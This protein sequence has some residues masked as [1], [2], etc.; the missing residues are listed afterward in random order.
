M[1]IYLGSEIFF[2]KEKAKEIRFNEHMFSLEKITFIHDHLL[3][4]L[5]TIIYF[6]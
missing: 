4:V 2:R 1:L 3:I 5:R 6:K